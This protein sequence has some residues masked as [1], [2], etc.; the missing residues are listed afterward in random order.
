MSSV[1]IAPP[2][3]TLRHEL[4]VSEA[5]HQNSV[6]IGIRSDAPASFAGIRISHNWCTT[7][8]LKSLRPDE[9]SEASGQPRFNGSPYIDPGPAGPP[10]HAAAC[11]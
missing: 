1:M 2:F 7:A 8:T 4:L 9:R 6:L 3:T 11:L 10:I 5:L